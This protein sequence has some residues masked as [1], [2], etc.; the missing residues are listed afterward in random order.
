MTHTVK[1]GET[2]GKIARLHGMTLA[3]LLELNPQFRANPNIVHVGDVL[4]ISSEVPIPT[5]PTTG[6]PSPFAAR[7]ASIAKAQRDKFQ[8]MNEADPRLCAEIKK[9]TE[10]IGARFINCTGHAWSAVFVS[11][12]VKEAGA[13]AAEFRFSIRHSEF[14][15]KAIQNAINGV[16]VFHGLEIT[17]HA[18]NVGDI[19]QNNRGTN[20]FDFNTAKRET[21]YESHSVIVVEIGQDG[22]GRFALC[23]GGN[24]S[25]SVRDSKVRLSPQGF[26]LQR[27]RSPFISV[28]KNL[29]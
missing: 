11:W 13:T 28:I 16:G 20:R 6:T 24:E 8:L 15:H 22:D 2:L 21:R 4:V 10:D 7:L 5:T 14:V 23:I 1:R 25:N 18:P 17:A 3:K 26:I 9:W 12:C 27:G 19:I 29:K